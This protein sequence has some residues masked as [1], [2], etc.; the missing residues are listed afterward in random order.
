M[1]SKRNKQKFNQDCGDDYGS[2]PT[3]IIIDN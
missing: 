1:E 3:T 2:G